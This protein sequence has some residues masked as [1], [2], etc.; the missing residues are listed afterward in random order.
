M[1]KYIKNVKF[2]LM[3]MLSSFVL[4][5]CQDAISSSSMKQTKNPFFNY[6]FTK[7]NDIRSESESGENDI[8]SESESGEDD[9]RS[10]PESEKGVIS[11]KPAIPPY[12]VPWLIFAKKGEPTI[13]YSIELHKNSVPN[14]TQF[15]HP[16]FKHLVS[17]NK[18][19]L[20]KNFFITVRDKSLKNEGYDNSLIKSVCNFIFLFF[21][22]LDKNIQNKDDSFTVFISKLKSLTLIDYRN[23]DCVRFEDK[24]K[25]MINYQYSNPKCNSNKIV[26]YDSLNPSLSMLLNNNCYFSRIHLKKKTKTNADNVFDH[27]KFYTSNLD[28][29]LFKSLKYLDV[30]GMGFGSENLISVFLCD[31]LLQ[32]LEGL[33][34]IFLEQGSDYDNKIKAPSDLSLRNKPKSIMKYLL[35]NCNKNLEYIT[36]DF[37]GCDDLS[38][39][40]RVEA[41]FNYNAALLKRYCYQNGLLKKLDRFWYLMNET[42]SNSE[43]KNFTNWQNLAK[44]IHEQETFE[45]ARLKSTEITSS[46]PKCLYLHTE[47]DPKKDRKILSFFNTFK[48]SKTRK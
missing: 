38:Y 25:V 29:K 33:R 34:F 22:T 11:S 32:Q 8:R 47:M 18:K 3:L 35:R 44:Y 7:K 23:Y 17:I 12:L 16:V 31:K 40:I 39:N 15:N 28:L 4:T 10:E 26:E 5:N 24:G 42:E 21:D 46:V 48:I 9:I 41:A 19:T 1:N 27:N 45:S 36:L 20:D 13:S 37:S 14:I 6:Y 2:T 43:A 30:T